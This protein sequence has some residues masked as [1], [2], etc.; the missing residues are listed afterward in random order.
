MKKAILVV[1]SS[2]LIVGCATEPKFYPNEY[3]Q[4][5]GNKQA[6]IDFKVC[7]AQ[8]EDQVTAGETAWDV[9]IGVAMVASVARTA[10]NGYQSGRIGDNAAL[11]STSNTE[12][13]MKRYVEICL[14]KKGYEVSGWS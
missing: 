12:E 7:E 13:N 14:K 10:T 4:K 8:A 3:Y 5:V 1:I 6:M 11:A 9:F 2:I